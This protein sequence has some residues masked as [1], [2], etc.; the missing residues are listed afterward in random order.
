MRFVATIL[1]VLVC[2]A[3]VYGADALAE[4]VRGY[5]QA[6]DASGRSSAADQIRAGFP[7]LTDAELSDALH[8]AAHF[9]AYQ[10][11]EQTFA[12]TL[13]DQTA[14]TV[15][16]RVPKNY[17]PQR[18][19]PIIL[20]YHG[21]GGGG[22]DLIGPIARLFGDDAE[23]YLIAGIDQYQPN[24]VDSKRSWRPEY[25]LV[26]Q[27]LKSH[28]NID[29]GRVYATGFS[30][31]GY[32]AW[33]MAIFYGDEIA[34]SIPVASA[35]DAAPEIPG[36][37]E[38]LLPNVS[39]TPV[40]NVWGSNDRLAVL[41]IDLQTPQGT[42]H[43][44]NQKLIPI[45]KKMNLPITSYIVKGGGHSFEPPRDLMLQMLKK[46]RLNYPREISKRFRYLNQARAD[47]IEGLSWDGD[48]W[49]LGRRELPDVPGQSR[50]QAIAQMLEATLG[51]IH[52]KVEAQDISISFSHLGELAIWFG[53]S[54]IDW[55]KPI[56]VSANGKIVFEGMIERDVRIALSQAMRTRDFDRIRWAGLKISKDRT[57]KL[58]DPET[59]DLPAIV[60]EKPK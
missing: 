41:G 36:M 29:S 31:G 51:S 15:F 35:F 8:R 18:A 57:A 48:Q 38:M 28:F 5:V 26:I 1:A 16:V 49:G 13:E 27:S 6:S 60:W 46:T 55:S 17:S 34:A 59:D 50:E 25:R 20:A 21:T 22:H 33:S 32:V 54:M 24:N 23:N 56:R 30:G 19:W 37:W 4:R 11:G 58:I 7:R 43:E 44:L 3:P 12:I 53:E 10:P 39:N 52:G 47:W 42:N 2:W 40:L 45:A 14:R 9:E